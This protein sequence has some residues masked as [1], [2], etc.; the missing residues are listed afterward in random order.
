M[1]GVH[2][3]PGGA[4]PFFDFPIS[5][6]TGSVIELDLIWKRE[7]YHLR[8]DLLDQPEVSRKFDLLESY[9][10]SKARGRLEPDRLLTAALSSLRTGLFCPSASL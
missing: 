10:L 2:F 1:M 3:H 6:L 7:L 8:D 5:E 4:A 9:L